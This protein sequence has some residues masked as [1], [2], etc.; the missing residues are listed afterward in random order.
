M[1]RFLNTL[2]SIQSDRNRKIF[3][4]P[5]SGATD[6][7]GYI[8]QVSVEVVEEKQKEMLPKLIKERKQFKD[9]P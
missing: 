2:S 1:D 6:W 7:S 3:K 5:H 8:R 9:I 4:S